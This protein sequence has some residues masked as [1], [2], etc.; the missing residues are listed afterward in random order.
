MG[1]GAVP[2]TIEKAFRDRAQK[3]NKVQVFCA[4]AGYRGD[5]VV[6]VSF[7]GGSFVLTPPRHLLLDRRLGRLSPAQF[8]QEYF[9]F[10][11]QSFL[12]N[13]YNWDTILDGRR[14]V[15]VCS[16][17]ADDATCHRRV[18][19]KFLKKFGAV[20]KGKLRR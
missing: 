9:K 11:E 3:K 4:D 7:Q 20:Y 17:G 8:E 10:L 15:L 5:D 16:C 19:I 18:L 6:D 13:R 1:A 12:Q 14:L 2:L